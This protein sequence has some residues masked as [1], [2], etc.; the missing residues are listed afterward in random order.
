MANENKPVIKIG[1]HSFPSQLDAY[2]VKKQPGWGLNLARAIESQ[3]FYRDNGSQCR[4]YT[5]K[6]QMVE[7]RMYAKGLQSMKKYKDKLGTNGD[8]SL[9]NLSDKP[10]TIIP[11]LVDI[12]CNGM[13]NRDYSIVAHAVDKLSIDAKI[14]YR[15]SIEDDMFAKDVIL[16]A[17]KS[18]GKDIANMPIDKLPETED[19]LNL[20][21]QL[22]YKPSIEL[23]NE[24]AIDVVFKENRYS[25]TVEKLVKKDLTI[26][27][28]AW[29]K[30]Y[31]NPQRG[32][33][34]KYVD[35]E[36]KIH[37]YTDDMFF[38][39]CFYHGEAETVLIS[40]LLIEHQWLNEAQYEDLKKQLE[41]SGNNWSTY[42]KIDPNEQIKGTTTILNFTYRTTRNRAKKIKD[43]KSGSKSVIPTSYKNGETKRD[44]FKIVTIEEEILFE[45]IYVLGTDIILKWEVAENLA[46]PKSNK[47]KVVDQYIGIAPN[48]ERGYV[49]SL[50]Q[51]MIP[52]EDKLNVIELKAEQ[53]IQKITPDGFQIDVSALADLDLGDGKALTPM[54]HL[55]MLMQTGSVFTNSYNQ[56]GDFNYAKDIIREFKTGD[57][58]GKLNGLSQ[59]REVYFNMLREVIGLNKASDAST[60][61]K[62][63]LVGLQKLASRSSNTATRHILD[64]AND[65]T[66]RLAEAVTYRFGDVMRYSELREDYARKIG[67]TAVVDLEYASKLHLHDFA[68]FLELEPDDEEK[69]K[70]EADLTIEVQNG[71]I[72]TDDKYKVLNIKNRKYSYQYLGILKE[73]NAK[74][75]EERKAR[76]IELQTK[77]NI[78]STQAAE[79]AKQAT[80]QLEATVK[81]EVQMITN[82]GLI[83][84]E[85]AKGEQDRLTQELKNKGMV[86]ANSANFSGQMQKQEFIEDKK[87]ER[88]LKQ[89]SIQAEISDQKA[90][91]KAPKDFE[92]EAYEM[93][94]FSL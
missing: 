59:Q 92:A 16:K 33:V 89:G 21:L 88:V 27:G 48:K 24:L 61:D 63:S 67:A 9:L 20:H 36:Y 4:F 69:A 7:R 25:D 80:Y 58:I 55:N 35:P 93:D 64:G 86:D 60:P 52:V 87:D 73:K 82:Q 40:D 72:G 94:E 47:Q 34:I 91:N 3:W 68:I 81:K 44:D 11:K 71:T 66:L 19:E 26:L 85:V 56:G 28:E 50:V 43:K 17:Q 74:R 10:I 37:P 53:I 76:E 79:A 18:I 2:E 54:D 62:E 5:R 29:V 77:G 49:D 78:E 32:I 51:R 46:R 57:S 23:S 38:N 42:H 84:K 13:S 30:H 14:S 15:K 31:F 8:L 65:L 12:V 39:N 45:G 70:L 75:A 90:N 1:N 6:E 22:E 83:D 41:Y